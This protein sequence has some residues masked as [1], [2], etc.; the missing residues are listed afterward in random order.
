MVAALINNRYNEGV[1]RLSFRGSALLV[2]VR[3]I[4]RSDGSLLLIDLVSECVIN[5]TC[6]V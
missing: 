5:V 1:P 2:K 3:L 4:S 6:F